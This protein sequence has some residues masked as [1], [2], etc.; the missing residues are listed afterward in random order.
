MELE[1]T[2]VVGAEATIHEVFDF[3]VVEMKLL[4]S[5]P[6]DGPMKIGAGEGE[7]RDRD[8]AR[9]FFEL[10]EVAGAVELFVVLLGVG[11]SRGIS[12]EGWCVGEDGFLHS[13]TFQ[14]CPSLDYQLAR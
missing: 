12:F 13:G 1:F 10:D 11:Q 7:I 2:G 14:G 9:F 5:P 4:I 6:K 3:Q 8:V